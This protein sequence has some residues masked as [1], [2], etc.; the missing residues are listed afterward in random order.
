[1][2]APPGYAEIEAVLRAFDRCDGDAELARM[3]DR[4]DHPAASGAAW[5]LRMG[6]RG[7]AEAMLER[8][9]EA[10]AGP[11]SGAGMPWFTPRPVPEND[12]RRRPGAG[13]WDVW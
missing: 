12:A 5:T 6:R 11:P 4:I 7:E 1:M 13:G 3:L 2:T 9:L 10:L 8:A